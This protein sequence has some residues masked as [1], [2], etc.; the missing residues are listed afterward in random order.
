MI[1]KKEWV[2]KERK[3]VFETPIYEYKGYFLFG[4]IPIYIKRHSNFR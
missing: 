2:S 1:I 4:I 3:G